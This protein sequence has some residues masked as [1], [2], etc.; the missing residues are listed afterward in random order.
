MH[1]VL[2][3]IAMSF[4]TYLFM[5]LTLVKMLLS[6][7]RQLSKAFESMVQTPAKK[8]NLILSE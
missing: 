3:R 8:A 1:Q 4:S 5:N 2:E 7:N 6:G